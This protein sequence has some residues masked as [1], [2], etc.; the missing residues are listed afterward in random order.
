MS[1]FILTIVNTYLLTGFYPVGGGGG[2]GEASTPNSLASTTKK[3]Q[4]Q[5]KLL[6]SRPYL[7][8]KIYLE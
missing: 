5:Y 8:V 6:W 7:S 1:V 4:L 3:F 2:G